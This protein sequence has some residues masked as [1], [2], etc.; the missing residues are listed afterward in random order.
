LARD[1]ADIALLDID[2]AALQAAAAGPGLRQRADPRGL[3]GRALSR[4][5][6]AHPRRAGPVD[7][8]LNN[9]GQSARTHE[10]FRRSDLETLD[11]MLAIT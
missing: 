11:F 8:L 5:D 1:H 6:S 3:H 7:I 4:R 9:V 2:E 10:R